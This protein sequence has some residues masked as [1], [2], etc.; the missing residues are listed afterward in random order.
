M[1]TQRQADVVDSMSVGEYEVVDLG[2]GRVDDA[3][4]PA[5]LGLLEIDSVVQPATD[6]APQ[7]DAEPTPRRAALALA[8]AFV[9]GLTTGIVAPHARS[10][11]DADAPLALEAGPAT[12]GAEIAPLSASFAG[13][14]V[15]VPVHN[16]GSRDITV[17]SATLIGWSQSDPGFPREPVTVPTGQTRTV[18]AAV[19][20]DCERPKPPTATIVE[21]R[22]RTDDLGVVGMTMPLSEPARDLTTLWEQFCSAAGQG[23]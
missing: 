8:L 15:D 23:G 4:L 12:A 20:L 2:H 1:S 5:E 6:G 13:A 11:G 22:V 19:E 18:A 17:L 14:S 7:P 9:L 3:G 10:D 16:A 21:V